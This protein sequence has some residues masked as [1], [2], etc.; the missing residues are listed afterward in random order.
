MSKWS[1]IVVSWAVTFVDHIKAIIAPSYCV[2]CRIFLS[3]GFMCK[4]CLGLIKPIAS[5]HIKVT[6]KY[7]IPVHALSFYRDPLISLVW[8][9]YYSHRLASQQLGQL[10]VERI[11]F[12]SMDFDYI[13][14][15]PLHWRSYASRGYNQAEVIADVIS[16]ATGKPLVSLVER[17]VYNR[18]QVSAGRDERVGNIAGVFSL[19][20]DALAYKGKKLLVVDDVMTTGATMKEVLHV[21]CKIAPE[22]MHAVVVCRSLL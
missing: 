16:K 4:P 12:H 17:S 15:V 9:K 10:M 18:S 13:V 20:S 6:K 19:S 5:T 8:S 1:D 21:L 22:S 11:P 7:A 14:P 2:S 3:A